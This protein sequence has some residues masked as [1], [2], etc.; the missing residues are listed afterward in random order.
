MTSFAR[1][2]DA[3]ACYAAY[4]TAREAARAAS[5]E[6]PFIP[7]FITGA[8]SAGA[9]SSLPVTELAER[10]R[11]LHFEANAWP[12]DDGRLVLDFYMPRGRM[13]FFEAY[14]EAALAALLA[15][16]DR[17]ADGA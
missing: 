4:A 10:L 1:R 14:D 12:L 2:K 5:I 16:F 17:R 11:A 15:L 6:E 13:F 9:L 3:P 7:G 8:E